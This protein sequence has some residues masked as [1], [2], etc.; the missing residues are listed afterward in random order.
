MQ[1][2]GLKIT[3][4]KQ[5]REHSEKR[6]KTVL[7]WGLGLEVNL[8]KLKQFFS[9]FQEIRVSSNT[10]LKDFDRYHVRKKQGSWGQFS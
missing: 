10:I 2:L 8:A 3:P 1:R 7:E 9:G 5:R 6:G 4:G